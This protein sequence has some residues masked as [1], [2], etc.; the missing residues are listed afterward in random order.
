MVEGVLGE[1]VE[2]FA[3]HNLSTKLEWDAAYCRS[4]LHLLLLES[5]YNGVK[6]VRD[7]V[8]EV[9]GFARSP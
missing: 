6:A 8:Q 3:I 9:A 2:N 4:L 7:F 1:V 5:L